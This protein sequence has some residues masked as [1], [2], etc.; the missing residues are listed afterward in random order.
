MSVARLLLATLALATGKRIYTREQDAERMS[1]DTLRSL[2][3]GLQGLP[4][5]GLQA[6]LEEVPIDR[7][8]LMRSS[9]VLRFLQERGSKDQARWK[10][11]L[12]AMEKSFVA[13]LEAQA[14]ELFQKL[15]QDEGVQESLPTTTTTTT[16]LQPLAVAVK[17]A[18]SK[19][20]GVLAAHRAAIHN[21]AATLRFLHEVGVSINATDNFGQAPAHVAA[22]RGNVEALKALREVGADMEAADNAGDTPLHAAAVYCEVEAVRFLIQAGV[23]KTAVNKNGKT[24]ADISACA[25]E[26]EVEL[27]LQDEE[28]AQKPQPTATANTTSP[29][30]TAT[31]VQLPAISVREA[32]E[33][34]NVS[35]LAAPQGRGQFIGR[36][37]RSFRRG[38]MDA[39]ALCSSKQPFGGAAVPPRGGSKHGGGRP[40]GKHTAAHCSQVWPGRCSALPVPGRDERERR[41]L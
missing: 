21:R 29:S 2:V 36:I 4:E 22:K 17:E 40:S 12:A 6:M 7:D 28:A 9:E 41:E 32:A 35:A 18:A 38:W 3:K 27:L 24:P 25:Y 30:P 8:G 1:S 16:S 23:N 19:D 34:G 10:E 31:R 39:G 14:K 5:E 20:V 15:R 11:R 13:S 33:K 37:A 26:Q